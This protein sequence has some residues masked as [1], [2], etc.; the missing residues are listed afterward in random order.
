MT[1]KQNISFTTEYLV[2]QLKNSATRS[3]ETSAFWDSS[4][5]SVRSLNWHSV[6]WIF[7]CIFLLRAYGVPVSLWNREKP[8]LLQS[9][10]TRDAAKTCSIKVSQKA[11]QVVNML[12]TS[13]DY[14]KCRPTLH[15]KWS[16]PLRISS[17]NVTKS[18]RNC[19]FVHIYWRNP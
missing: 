14:K 10:H 5:Q 12:T 6:Y 8:R 16:G 3:V 9:F 4:L 7:N 13:M 18:A 1:P 11:K 2:N 19:W 17:I 15:K